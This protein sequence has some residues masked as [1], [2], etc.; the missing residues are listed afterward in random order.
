MWTRSSWAGPDGGN[1]PV[2][3]YAYSTNTGEMTAIDYS[4]STP[5]I[6]V[7]VN[8]LGQQAT[9]TGHNYGVPCD[10]VQLRRERGPPLVRR[11]SRRTNHAAA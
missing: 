5:D 9:V 7:T 1:P 10:P 11:L 3:S 6:G 4:D 2:T 8:Y